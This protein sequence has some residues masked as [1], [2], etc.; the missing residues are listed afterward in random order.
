MKVY[1]VADNIVSSLGFDTFQHFTALSDLKSGIKEIN[2]NKIAK[3]PLFG[4]Q[5]DTG[6]L[7]DNFEWERKSYF[8]R[9]EKMFIISISNVLNSVPK[10]EKSRLLLIISTTKGNIDLH[11]GDLKIPE[12]RIGLSSM[13][14][15][16]GSFFKL[17]NTPLVISN[18]CIS[19]LSAIIT[20]KKL[21][22]MGMY[23]HVVVAGGDILSEFVVSGFQC[24][25]AISSSPCKPYDLHRNGISLGEACGSLLLSNDPDLCSQKLSYASLSGGGQSNDANH[26]S[27]PSRTAKGLKIAIEKALATSQL[28]GD[29]I[30]YINSHGTGTLFNDEMESLAFSDLGF[31][32]VPVNSLKG[33]FGHTLGASGVIET[34]MAIWQLNNG[35]LFKSLGFEEEGVSGKINVLKAHQNGENLQYV[36]KTASGFGGCN[37]ALVL[38]KE[39]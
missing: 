26:I 33:Y 20:A 36:M 5:I 3:G 4:A 12:E 38:K 31:Q 8:T 9:L 6:E 1:S 13:A 23:D 2:D 16:I 24:L 39:N 10:L 22:S 35:L 25:M 15:T 32:N 11:T 19:G 18:A 28:P 37:A 17:T 7:E 34:I 30:R 29:A 14:K 21:I 27:G